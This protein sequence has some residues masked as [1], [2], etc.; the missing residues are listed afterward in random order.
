MHSTNTPTPRRAPRAPRA[1][2][3]AYCVLALALAGGA[4]SADA[5]MGPSGPGWSLRRHM[6]P[7]AMFPLHDSSDDFPSLLSPRHM[8]NTMHALEHE[9]D[10]LLSGILESSPASASAGGDGN[11]TAVDARSHTEL[12]LRPRFDVED[13]ADAFTLTAAT[14]GLQKEDL[15]V[16]VVDGAD[17]AA[18]LIVAGHTSTPT[19]SDGPASGDGP[20]SESS[21][22]A[23][24][25]APS[26]SAESPASP[27]SLPV[28]AFYSKFERRIKLPSEVE[29]DQM[30][31]AYQN[32]LLSV[33]IPK[34]AKR[35]ALK[36]RVPI[37]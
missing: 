16:E 7:Y 8:L 6:S 31:A 28:K 13:S 26:T 14:P 35:Q 9:A 21:T 3:R 22:P 1:F 10:K 23:G 30:R 32:G 36:L 29:R 18:Y 25:T 37:S 15:S 17:G 11:L 34:S 4:R 5:F 24:E 20:A 12:R 33:T 19:A 2:A 27:A